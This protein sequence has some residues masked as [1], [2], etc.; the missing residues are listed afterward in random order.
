M[1]RATV[2]V[3]ALALAG[4]GGIRGPAER[5]QITPSKSKSLEL[6]VTVAAPGCMGVCRPT[7]KLGLPPTSAK[8]HARLPDVSEYQACVDR[9]VPVV[10]RLYE[11]GL[12]REDRNAACNARRLHRWHQ[13]FGG[14]TYLFP[15]SCTAEANATVS[16]VR[17]LGGLNGPIIADAEVALPNG[18]VRCF[19][20]QIHRVLPSYPTA[21]YTGCYSGL[22]IVGP[23]WVPDYGV[24][25]PC[26]RGG[27]PWIA[28]QYI[29]GTWCGESYVTDC[30]ID[31]G[32]LKLRPA[33]PCNAQCRVLRADIAGRER[34][35]SL[36]TRAEHAD[37]LLIQFW[38]SRR[39]QTTALR[40]DV[41]GREVQR[42]ALLKSIEADNR[43][44]ALWRS[45]L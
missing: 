40:R 6:S 35:R 34:Q 17:S 37:W 39:P 25:A 36:A 32:I 27:H 16:I 19:L 13:W 18:F 44:I 23:W 29:D 11:S 5:V 2:V 41:H 12:A 26:T 31:N 38:R 45:K 3:V 33:R 4:C 24:S 42:Q 28:W 22:E 15:G 1:K 7:F 14:Y 43:L 8:G 9:N 30:S 10:I 20:A 21:T